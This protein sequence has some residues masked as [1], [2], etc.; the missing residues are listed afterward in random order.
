MTPRV[1]HITIYG[2][3]L[4]RMVDFYRDTLG[5]P[6]LA[7]DDAF[8]YARVDGGSVHIGLEAGETNPDLGVY[9]G[10]HTGIGFEVPDVDAAYETLKAKGVTFSMPPKRQPWG[11]YMAMFLD[12]DG[13]V[14]QLIPIEE[15]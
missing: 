5:L 1:A 3:D 9:I 15:R 13:N 4:R 12:P 6:L 11:G 8:H 10:I 14:L 2:R 7:N